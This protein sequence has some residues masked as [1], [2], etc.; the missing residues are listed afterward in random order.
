MFHLRQHV[1]YA[2]DVVGGGVSL[3]GDSFCFTKKKFHTC[4]RREQEGGIAK[5]NFPPL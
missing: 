4:Y 1:T 2:I 3:R 5:P